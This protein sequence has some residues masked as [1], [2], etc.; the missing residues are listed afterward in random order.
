MENLYS[1]RNI[2][3]KTHTNSVFEEK[4]MKTCEHLCVAIWNLLE[5]EWI[6]NCDD[7]VMIIIIWYD[8]G[9]C[10]SL[11][12]WL[13]VRIDN[14]GC[15]TMTGTQNQ[16]RVRGEWDE[17]AQVGVGRNHRWKIRKILIKASMDLH[18]SG[19]KCGWGAAIFWE[20]GKI[21]KQIKSEAGICA[22]PWA[23]CKWET[24]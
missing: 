4:R 5:S 23:R 21:L 20:I 22:R 14:G 3:F 19:Y 2:K 16:S 6:H 12:L 10:V 1:Q 18:M 11:L 15:V 24:W 8:Y 9:G 13:W 7:V 17:W